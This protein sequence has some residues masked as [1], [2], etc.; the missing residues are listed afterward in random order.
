MT[1]YLTDDFK[2][3][4]LLYSGLSFNSSQKNGRKNMFDPRLFMASKEITSEFIH[5]N[6][7]KN[8]TIVLLLYGTYL[9]WAS[10]SSLWSSLWVLEAFMG[11]DWPE[12]GSALT[13]LS[14][15]GNMSN[16]SKQIKEIPEQIKINFTLLRILWPISI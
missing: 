11:C 5:A 15:K 2:K 12:E 16:T 9:L 14:D 1:W 10:S 6:L 4:I 8:L 13:P 3:Q 7:R